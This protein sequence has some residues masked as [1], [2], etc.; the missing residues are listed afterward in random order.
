MIANRLASADFF[1]G[2]IVGHASIDAVEDLALRE[3]SVFEARDF[4]GRH[5]GLAV[6]MFVKHELDSGVRK[7]DELQRYSINADGIK[8]IGMG[9]FDDL[10]L[11]EPSPGQIAGGIGAGERMFANVRGAYQLDA[12][13]VTDAGVLHFDHLR[14]FRFGDVE[15]F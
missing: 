5:D 15:S 12:G 2:L 13:V 4:F 8:L 7:A 6:Q 1:L 11:G 14:D 10:R 3:T 9:D